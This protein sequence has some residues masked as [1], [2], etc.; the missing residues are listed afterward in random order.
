MR[1]LSLLLGTPLPLL[2]LGACASNGEFPSLQPREIER[3]L[4]ERDKAPPPPPI[5]DDPR[6]T[7]RARA[8]VAGVREGDAVFASQAARAE[9]AAAR[10]GGAGSDSWVEAQQALSRA[11]A[12]R[13]LTVNVLAELDAFSLAQAA[14]TTPVSAADM[15]AILDAVR[16]GQ[17]IADRQ[18]QRLD[19]LR[20]SLRP[21]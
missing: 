5:A 14:S 3:E 21:I 9:R 13:A 18:Q 2:L 1:P 15:A 7:A 11:E 19:R 8:L 20:A 10:A 4:A 6:L 16:E 17:A 12:A